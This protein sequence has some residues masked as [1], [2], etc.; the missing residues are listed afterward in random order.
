MFGAR[1]P[2]LPS[3]HKIQYDEHDY[4][5]EHVYDDEHDYDDEQDYD[6]EHV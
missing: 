2:P 1:G 4:D 5:D 6:D 3:A